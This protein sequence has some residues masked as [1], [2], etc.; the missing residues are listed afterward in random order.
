MAGI[1]TE[2]THVGTAMADLVITNAK[3]VTVDSNFSI[4]KAVAPPIRPPIR[5]TSGT[6]VL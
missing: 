1:E 4:K 5:Q 6:R 3:V 2:S